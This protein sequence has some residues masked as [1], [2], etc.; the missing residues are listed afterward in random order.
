MA[1]FIYFI[2]LC[3]EKL[4][5]FVPYFIDSISH[6]ENRARTE[7]KNELKINNHTTNHLYEYKISK[8][9]WFRI[10]L[11]FIYTHKYIGYRFYMK[12]VIVIFFESF[13]CIYTYICRVVI[14]QRRRRRKKRTRPLC[15]TSQLYGT[16]H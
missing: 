16:P 2:Q 6:P 15:A 8:W 9:K 4:H 5:L 1:K 11:T 14:E 12:Y 7:E 13:C 10:L 3:V